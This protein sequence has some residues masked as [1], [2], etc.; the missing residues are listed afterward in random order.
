M[1]SQP[2]NTPLRAPNSTLTSGCNR[3]AVEAISRLALVPQPS[4]TAPSTSAVLPSASTGNCLLCGAPVT[5]GSRI[6][7]RK[8]CE[9][10]RPAAYF[11][12][13]AVRALKVLDESRQRQARKALL[14]AAN[15]LASGRA[16]GS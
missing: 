11:I 9:E 3:I 12:A 6:S 8:R 16:A 5:G 4:A 14:A 13:A 15:G 7:P 2:A 1:R 10:C